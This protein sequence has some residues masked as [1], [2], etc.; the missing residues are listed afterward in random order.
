MAI[1]MKKYDRN[2]HI[3]ELVSDACQRIFLDLSMFK[4]QKTIPAQKYRD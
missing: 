4:S 1:N 3:F 2:E